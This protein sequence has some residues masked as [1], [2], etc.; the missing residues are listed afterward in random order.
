MRMALIIDSANPKHFF[1]HPVSPSLFSCHGGSECWKNCLLFSQA[2]KFPLCVLKERK[3]SSR[4]FQK[5][6][7]LLFHRLGVA[8]GIL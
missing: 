5:P 6:E 1:T 2:L 8:V 4:Y 7:L 3:V